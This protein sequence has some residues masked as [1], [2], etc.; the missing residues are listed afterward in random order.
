MANPQIEVE[1]GANIN[2]LKKAVDGSIISLKELET[3]AKDLGK[4]LESA[5]DVNS[6][7][8][9]N[10]ELAETKQAIQAL[11]G[12]GSNNPIRG[13]GDSA[14][15]AA[16]Q[17]DK[18]SRSTTNANGVAIEFSRIIQDAPFGIIGVG[19][20]IQQLTAN[21]AQVSRAAGGAGAAIK[22]SLT[23]L[24]S[25]ANLLVLGISAV[26]SGL[27]LYAMSARSA[28]PEIEALEKA[29]ESFND[30][31][32]ETD[33]LLGAEVLGQFLKEVGLVESQNIA[34]RL[35]DVRTFTSAGQVVDAL[36]GKIQNLR[37]GE[38]DLLAKFLQTEITN[39]T[40]SASNATTELTKKLASKDID[41]Y[42][43]LLGKINEQ[44]AFYDNGTKK[45]TQST[46]ELQQVINTFSTDPLVDAYFEAVR[47]GAEFRNSLEAAAAGLT[48]NEGKPKGIV[49]NGID[50]GGPPIIEIP[51]IDTS[52]FDQ[53]LSAIENVKSQF[54]SF[55]GDFESAAETFVSNI[56][57][58]VRDGLA[59]TFTNLG[60]DIGIALA[61]GQN[62]IKTIGNSLLDSLGAF[63]GD[64]GQQLIAVGVAGLAFTTLLETI[65][66]GGPAAIPAAIGAIAAGTALVALSGALRTTAGKGLSGGGGASGVGT[67]GVGTGSSFSGSGGATGF[68][69]E[70]NINLVGS[71]RIAGNDLLYVIDRSKENQI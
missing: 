65:K 66:A 56:N 3:K 16:P 47:Q 38:L 17:L 71:F 50:L 49:D 55:G 68:S 43:G 57:S 27:T 15:L 51:D 23:A 34:G 32:K 58:I 11:K 30:T 5:T 2:G 45:S 70:R 36:A 33:R 29:Q 46:K 19:N 64:F 10:R 42:S 18:L 26:T 20:N 39:A 41:L 63:I 12:F 13:L 54:E 69:A 22:A 48:G 25:P 35:I 24:I 4:S 1:V 21:F 44:L 28:K 9:Y 37:K 60:N 6:I 67:S 8:I 7:S 53:F 40:R 61:S 52:Q 59:N 14:G 31:L 62:V